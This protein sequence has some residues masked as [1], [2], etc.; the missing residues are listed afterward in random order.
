MHNKRV[1]IPV[2]S[3]GVILLLG[4]GLL[5]FAGPQG[6]PSEESPSTSAEVNG[7][8]A[9]NA[10]LV[11]VAKEVNPSV[12]NISTTSVIKRSRSSRRSPSEDWDPF[13]DFFGDEFFKRFFDEPQTRQRKSLGSGVIVREDGYILTN[14]HVVAG[15]DE[16]KVTVNDKKEYDAKLI[17]RDEDTDVAVIKIDAKDMQ[18]PKLGDSDKIQ[19]GELVLAIGNPLRLSHSVTMGIISATGRSNVGLATY[20]DFIQTDASINPG[21]S[22]G[23]LVNI[24]GEVIG[25]NTAILT[26]GAPGNIGIGFAIPINMAL[27]VMEKLMDKGQVVRG[28]LGVQLQEVESD[29]AEKYGLKESKGALIAAISPDGPAGKAG[30]KSGD[31]IIEFNGKTIEDVSHL[32][33]MVAEIGPDETVVI[34]AIRGGEE[35][36]F[37]ITLGERTKEA[38]ASLDGSESYPSEEEEAGEVEEWMGITVQALTEELAQRLGYKGISG[39]LIS[40]VDLE[41]PAAQVDNPPRPGDLIQEIEHKE[42]KNISD[43]KDAIKSV[44]DQKNVLVRFRR[45]G[46]ETWYALIKRQ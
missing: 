12:V 43:Y 8:R 10:T 16:I 7:L 22:G 11:K 27:D 40:D 6:T 23:P 14:N 20:E 34:K 44:R 28:W 4:L 25:I 2:I 32:K 31:L 18:V 24:D 17:G 3:I 42:I 13:K 30:M 46:T 21:N 5:I 9:F 45:S 26:A 38:M 37:R 41:K 36:E 35:K 33:K 1:L 19:V 39:V 15:A 29:I